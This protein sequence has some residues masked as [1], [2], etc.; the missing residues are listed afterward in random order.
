MI[1]PLAWISSLD[2]GIGVDGLGL[3]E[4]AELGLGIGDEH[5][6]IEPALVADQQRPVVGDQ[7]GEQGQ[8]EQDQEQPSD[9]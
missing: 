4:A 3:E 8:A 9:T 1:Q 5:R 6:E 2:R 7:L